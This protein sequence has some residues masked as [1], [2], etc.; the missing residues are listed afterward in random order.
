M[1]ITAHACRLVGHA[2]APQHGLGTSPQL[3]SRNT[4]VFRSLDIDHLRTDGE[5]RVER[6]HRVLEHHGH[7]GATEAPALRRCLGE[8]LFPLEHHRTRGLHSVG[9]QQAQ[10]C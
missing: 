10:K 6:R 7:L 1:R 9:R 2:D 8:Q 5:Q 4:R 3:T